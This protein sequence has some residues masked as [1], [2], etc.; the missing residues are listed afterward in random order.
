MRLLNLTCCLLGVLFL[1]S[2][3]KSFAQGLGAPLSPWLMPGA[4]HQFSNSV[5]GTLQV[6]WNPQQDLSL[7]YGQAF[8]RI[9][10]YISLNPGYL[11][12][13]GG[14]VLRQHSRDEQTFLN[15]IILTVPIKQFQIESRH[16]LWNRF[17]SHFKDQHLFRS[18]LRLIRTAQFKERK[19]RVYIFDELT[20][21]INRND[22]SRNRVGLGASVDILGWMNVDISYANQR[23][24]PV[25]K[26][27]IAFVMITVKI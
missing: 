20:F 13:K 21:H 27:N 17:S 11:L 7:V 6:G 23:D 18:R 4:S 14:A 16:L 26:L 8:I 22:W 15:G 25:G 1:S 2:F 24:Y 3:C 9:N 12:L 5:H 10:K 19:L